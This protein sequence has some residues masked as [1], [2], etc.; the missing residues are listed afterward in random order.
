MVDLV[1]IAFLVLL[2]GKVVQ[3][4]RRSPGL[5]ELYKKFADKTHA[6][7]EWTGIGV[8]VQGGKGYGVFWDGF[9]RVGI[10]SLGIHYKSLLFPR[11]HIPWSEAV[12]SKNP[13]WMGIP[14]GRRYRIDSPQLVEAAIF[15]SKKSGDRILR[16]E[17]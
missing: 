17:A 4:Y 14:Y 3:H 1:F 2:I 15:V 9:G 13:K 7:I 12:V 8:L 6:K 16:H 5:D 10:S 11:I